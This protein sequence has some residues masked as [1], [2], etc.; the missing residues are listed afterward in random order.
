MQRYYI[1]VIVDDHEGVLARIAS[2][3][4]QRGFNIDSI[5]ASETEAPELTRIT[6]ATT[7]ERE[8][9]EQMM[10]QIRKLEETRVLFLLDPDESVMRELLLIKIRCD[11]SNRSAL[12]EIVE[13]YR[14]QIIDL[15]KDSMIVQ[16]VGKPTKID[17]FLNVIEDYEI[18]EMCRSGLTAFERGPKS[19]E[20][21]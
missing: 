13:I 2:L 20:I 3:F 5:T 9:I 18:I 8:R 7:G 14:A 6:L 10:K 21:P 1:S 15:S 4:T 11:E 12:R 17:G 16:V 19:F